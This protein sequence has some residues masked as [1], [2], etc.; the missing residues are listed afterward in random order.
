M[1]FFLIGFTLKQ[2]IHT[3]IDSPSQC[4]CCLVVRS[5]LTLYNPMDHS[6]PGFSVHEISQSRIQEWVS[7]SYSRRS[8]QPRDQT[9]ISCIGSQI[10]YCWATR[11]APQGQYSSINQ[12]YLATS[13]HLRRL[14][15]Y[16]E[17]AKYKCYVRNSYGHYFRWSS[18]QSHVMCTIIIPILQMRKMRPRYIK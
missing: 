16:W 4:C 15:V 18:Q 10:F 12:N 5:C 6:P 8:S 3:A 17:Q 7:I 11:E 14:S 1:F 9:W 13:F 2:W